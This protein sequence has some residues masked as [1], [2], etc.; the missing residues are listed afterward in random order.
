MKLI[1]FKLEFI[2]FIELDLLVND[3]EGAAT[4]PNTMK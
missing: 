1:L 2:L 4:A 3:N